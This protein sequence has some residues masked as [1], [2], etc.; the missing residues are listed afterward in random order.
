MSVISTRS[1]P[2]ASSR[3]RTYVDPLQA[4]DPLAAAL[5]VEQRLAV[6]EHHVGAGGPGGAALALELRPGERRRR[7]DSR[8][9]SRPGPGAA[10]SVSGQAAQPLDRARERELRPAESLDEVAAPRR[11]EQLEVLELAVDRG[12]AARDPLGDRRL[13]GDDSVALEHQ[14]R[15]RAHPR[16]G[17]G[18]A[19]EQRTR[20]ATSGRAP[21]R[22]PL[23]GGGRSGARRARVRWA[24]RRRGARS[25]AK[26][27]L[28]TS[29]DQARSQS[30]S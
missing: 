30:A 26:A 29:P 6:A 20:S 2:V 5:D 4:E 13:A 24:A 9:R 21:S 23:P 16:A 14:L 22:R 11:S 25:G 18:R 19:L 15:Q 7:T 17:G 12:E 10:P 1:K 27:S 8:G 3:S 28:V